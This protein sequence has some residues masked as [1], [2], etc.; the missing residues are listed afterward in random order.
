[1][2]LFQAV[3]YLAAIILLLVAAFA[4]PQRVSLG[5]IAAAC[6]LAAYALPSIT[7]AA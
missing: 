4:A 1:M 6:A 7:E 5:M 2:M 3:L